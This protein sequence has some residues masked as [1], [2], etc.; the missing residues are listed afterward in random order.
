MG[1]YLSRFGETLVKNGYAVIPIMPGTKHP[2][3]WMNH[4][5]GDPWSAV[6]PSIERVR[7]WNRDK[8]LVEAGVG[9][10]LG[11]TCVGVDLDILNPGLAADML[12]WCEDNLGFGPPARIGLAPKRLLVFRVDAPIRKVTSKAFFDAEGRKCQVEIL[13]DG[14]QFVAYAVHPDTKKP[15]EWPDDDLIDTPYT[16]LPL[17]TLA[18]ANEIRTAFEKMCQDR[19]F[20]EKPRA[21]GQSL[22]TL[23][24]E[25]WTNTIDKGKTDLSLEKLR[26]TVFNIGNDA[27]SG[28]QDFDTWL[29]VGMAVFHQTDGSDEGFEIW[30]DWS[31]QSTKHVTAECERR[32]KSFDV[33][34]K[35]RR[36]ITA[37]WLIKIAGEVVDEKARAIVSDIKAAIAAASDEKSLREAAKLAKPFD[38]DPV[39]R[40]VL[41]LLVQ[42][43]FK[44]VLDMPMTVG[45]ARQLVRYESPGTPEIPKWLERWVYVSST[46]EFFNRISQATMKPEAFDNTFAREILTDMDQREGKSVSD[47]RPSDMALNVFRIEIVDQ[48]VYQPAVKGDIFDHA[49]RRCVNTYTDRLVPTIPPE[50]DLKA[51]TAIRLVQDHVAWLLPEPREAALMLSFLAHVVRGGRVRW[52]VLLHGVEGVGKTFFFQ[53]M[54]AILGSNN[55]KTIAPKELEKEF[56]PWA[57]G[58]QFNCIEEIRLH[59]HNRY[60]VVNSLK[61]HITNDEISV[62]KMRTDSYMAPNTATYL[63]LTN[64]ADALPIDNRDRRYMI[65]SA[66]PQTEDVTARGAD[67]FAKLFDAL[68]EHAGALRGWLQTYEAHPD[69]NADGRAP[70]TTHKRRLVAVVES[71]EVRLIREA[72]E[73]AG[74][75][76]GMTPYLLSTKLLGDALMEA[77][78]GVPGTRTLNRVLLDMGLSFV[79]RCRIPGGE[80]S[81]WWS[82]KPRDWMT[83]D[84]V[85]AEKIRE[86]MDP[87]L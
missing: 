57:E 39:S 63:A 9:I 24:T 1:G 67:Y 22:G 65:L 72:L 5:K 10:N 58:S 18:D 36:P 74:G 52:A 87:S 49:G 44:A 38:L 48:R 35:D 34:D 66:A 83:G 32:W 14:E 54:G 33:S 50:N 81:R 45:M 30:T 43:K 37:R 55:V 77:G 17:I 4:K 80:K 53:L 75:A 20:K 84:D 61:P 56:T 64:Y 73:D 28:E 21:N 40:E 85:D 25:D 27:L 19:G 70:M 15:Y 42:R 2:P 41:A 26:R 82:T 6:T 62:R 76:A 59:G 68:K 7:E 11:R 46:N 86:W 79:G 23:D 71:D 51:T 47:K 69:F 60:D 16:S 13:G 31:N 8:R 78:E 29:Q 12:A 3:N